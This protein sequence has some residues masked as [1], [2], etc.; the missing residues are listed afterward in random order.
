[1]AFLQGGAAVTQEI[2]WQKRQR[3]QPKKGGSLRK[4]QAQNLLQDFKS[5]YQQLY[6][7]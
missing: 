3:K 7:D 2:L 1:L 4:G 6:Q 5:G